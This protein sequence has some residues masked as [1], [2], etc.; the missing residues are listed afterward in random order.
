MIFFRIPKIIKLLH[1]QQKTTTDA[2]RDMQ[3]LL[4]ILSDDHDEWRQRVYVL[5]TTIRI[6]AQE[7][8]TLKESIARDE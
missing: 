1:E 4:R 7:I 2:L 6:Q 3:K 5:E 8:L